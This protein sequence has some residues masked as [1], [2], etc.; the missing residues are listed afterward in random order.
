MNNE[1]NKKYIRFGYLN[2]LFENNQRINNMKY[3]LD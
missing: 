1:S 2:I 3:N